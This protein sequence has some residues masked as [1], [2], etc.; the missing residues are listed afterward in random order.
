MAP[1]SLS[2]RSRATMTE[3]NMDSRS[4]K[5]PIHSLMMTST[6]S[7]SS[8]SSTV[9]CSTSMMWSRPLALISFR[10]C[11]AMYV[12]ST[13]YTFLAPFCAAQMARIPEP[14]PTSSTT[15][16]LNDRG[17]MRTALWYAVMR[18][19]SSS[20]SFWWYKYPYVQK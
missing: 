14:V 1:P 15:L 5:Y 12:A 4:R 8:T 13:A 7:G 11:V 9:L 18:A 17:F 2:Q 19:W 16:S 20:M 6:F 10:A 3:S